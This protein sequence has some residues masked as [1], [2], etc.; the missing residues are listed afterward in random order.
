MTSS[1]KLILTAVIT[2]V[3]IVL[4]NVITTEYH[5]RREREEAAKNKESK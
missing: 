2:I 3:T 1:G 5:L 4:A